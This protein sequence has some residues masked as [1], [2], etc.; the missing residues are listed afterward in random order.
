MYNFEVERYLGLW[1]EVQRDKTIWYEDI[2]DIECV[3]TELQ[4]NAW[5]PLYPIE[6]NNRAYSLTN[7]V[8]STT[9]VL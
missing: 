9:T 3:S 6:V 7:T 8:R 4:W 1:F 5:N 2:G